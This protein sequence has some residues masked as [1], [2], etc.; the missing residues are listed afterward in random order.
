MDPHHAQLCHEFNWLVVK[1]NAQATYHGPKLLQ[2]QTHGTNIDNYLTKLRQMQ[3]GVC[4]S[5]L[6]YMY[7]TQYKSFWNTARSCWTTVAKV[8]H[9]LFEALHHA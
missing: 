3:F 5:V 2:V 1:C 8:V 6:R 4:V 7:L 9:M